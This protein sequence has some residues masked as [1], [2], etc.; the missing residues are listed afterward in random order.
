MLSTPVVIENI[1]FTELTFRVLKVVGALPSTRL[2]EHVANVEVKPTVVFFPLRECLILIKNCAKFFD[3]TSKQFTLTL[4]DN[5]I[6][7]IDGSLVILSRTKNIHCALLGETT[8]V[9]RV[10]L[11]GRLT[12]NVNGLAVVKCYTKVRRVLR[13]VRLPNVVVTKLVKQ[14]HDLLFM[15]RVILRVGLEGKEKNFFPKCFH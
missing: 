6:R 5:I 10:C 14:I 2:G 11:L 1:G 12:L 4:R 8:V 3:Q 7:E 13:T 15:E 9:S